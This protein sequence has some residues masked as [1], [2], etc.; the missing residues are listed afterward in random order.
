MRQLL[1]FV[2]LLLEYPVFSQDDSLIK[3]I[4][5]DTAF[6]TELLIDPIELMPLFPGG[7]D[8]IWRV[9]ERNL[10]FEI[11]NSG[12]HLG[13]VYVNFVIDT[14]GRIDNLNINP[15]VIRTRRIVVDDMEINNEIIRVINLLKGWTP[16]E[17]NKRKVRCGFWIPI[18]IP[19]TDFKIPKKYATQLLIIGT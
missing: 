10:N 11:V 13:S 12:K 7:Q 16:A 18:Q 15:E 1:I 4:P 9:I 5:V 3:A 19:Y 17:I 14:L 8:S 2:L 6:E